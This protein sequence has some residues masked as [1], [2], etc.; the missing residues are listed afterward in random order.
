M[1]IHSQG[2]KEQIAFKAAFSQAMIEG[3]SKVETVTVPAE[4]LR[5]FEWQSSFYCR[6]HHCL[7]NICKYCG[8]MKAKKLSCGHNRTR[9]HESYCHFI[10]L[11]GLEPT[12]KHKIEHIPVSLFDF[13][14]LPPESILPEYITMKWLINKGACYT[15]RAKTKRVFKSNKI[16][17]T[18]HNLHKA[19]KSGLPVIHWVASKDKA[20]YRYYLSHSK[21]LRAAAGRT[22]TKE[23]RISIISKLFCIP[24]VSNARG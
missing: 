11:Q 5:K 3:A 6:K 19:I 15:G 12:L 16:R 23:E 24:E 9:G 2:P 7:H 8:G 1:A 14:P 13:T 10:V 4:F 17:R 22:L 18:E 20:L 21:K